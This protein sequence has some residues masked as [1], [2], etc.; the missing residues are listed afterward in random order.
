[1]SQYTFNTRAYGPNPKGSTLTWEDLD[2]SLTF[3][4]VAHRLSTL[5]NCNKIY[6]LNNKSIKL[7]THLV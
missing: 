4:I 1:M 6:S 2:N 7:H 3:I 5:K